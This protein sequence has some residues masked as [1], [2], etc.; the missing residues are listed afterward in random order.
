MNPA[1]IRN[2]LRYAAGALVAK[3]LIAPQTGLAIA[4]DPVLVESLSLALGAVLGLIAEGFYALAKRAG[5][6]T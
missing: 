1:I 3:G 6:R 2:I 5:W 4:S